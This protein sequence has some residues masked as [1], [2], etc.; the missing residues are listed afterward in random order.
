MSPQPMLPAM[1]LAM[2]SEVHVENQRRMRRILARLRRSVEILAMTRRVSGE[3]ANFAAA[4]IS[5]IHRVV[6]YPSTIPE[7]GVGS[8]LPVWAKV[9]AK[10]RVM[11]ESSQVSAQKRQATM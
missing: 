8:I 9:R 5:S 2:V 3:D 7:P 11:A 10:P 1:R 4:A 6:E